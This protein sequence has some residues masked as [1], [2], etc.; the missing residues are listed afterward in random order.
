MAPMDIICIHYISSISTL[1][2]HNAMVAKMA[3]NSTSQASN[4]MPAV[5]LA[6]ERP[7]LTG[8]RTVFLAGTTSATGEA[9]WRESLAS[10]LGGQLPP[11]TARDIVLLNPKRDDWDSTWR[12]DFRDARWAE[13][14]QWELD[15]QDAAHLVVV[16]F[17]G[18]SPAPISLLELGLCVRSGRAVVC[19]LDNY[20]KRGN[21][22]AVC[23]RYGAVMVNTPEELAAKVA[24]RLMKES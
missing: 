19:A 11:D 1:Q 4:T 7:D 13:Q 17:H 16:F 8:R 5:V 12:E 18:V 21:V 24:E 23:R 6:P 9:D 15:M 14:V 22:E 10:A 20:S 3:L 2:L